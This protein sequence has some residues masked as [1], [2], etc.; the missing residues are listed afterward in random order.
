MD[1]NGKHNKNTINYFHKS[2]NNNKKINFLNN[3]IKR[4]KGENKVENKEKTIINKGDDLLYN[5]PGFYYDKNKNRYF[6]LKDKEILNK[7]N[8]RDNNNEI[9]VINNNQNKKLS[10]FKMIHL[11]H[12]MEKK[13]LQKYYNRAKYLKNS[14]YINIEYEGDKFPNTVYLFYLKKYLLIL[15]YFNDNNALT[16][17]MIYDISNNKFLKKIIIDDFFNDFIIIKNNLILI[18]NIIKISIIN[19]INNIIESRNKKIEINIISKFS[20][21]IKNIGRIS[22]VYKWPFITFE[23]NIYYYLIWNNFYNLDA[24]N[25]SDNRN[26]K[27]IKY[28]NDILYLPKNEI[29]K[30]KNIFK[31]NKVDI[32]KKYHYINL[33]INYDK[34]NN[35]NFYFFT[36]FGEIHKYKF[37]KNNIFTLK[38][39]ITNEILFNIPIIKICHFYNNN[40]LLISNQ[41]NIFNFDLINQTMTEININ[42]KFINDSLSNKN[43]KYKYK[44]FKYNEILN[45]VI[46]EKD[47]NII[48]YSLE[49]F[50]L[51]KKFKLDDYRYNILFINNSPILI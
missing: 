17:I 16:T 10:F 39:I 44:V 8:K 41:S 25:E 45:C 20:I 7:I 50:S 28:N 33:I 30:N 23:K 13:E 22:M 5:I 18:D 40:Y 19:D 49:N 9:K 26:S 29:N 2:K 12:I 11:S 27:L 36:P 6:S 42:N 14:N 4:K 3:K 24:Y 32:N 15:D 35:K 38:Q 47:D 34:K 1:F 21:N 46:Y 31:I 37:K 51:I 48:I 43:I